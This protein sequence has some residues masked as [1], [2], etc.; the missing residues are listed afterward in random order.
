VLSRGGRCGG[1]FEY[2]VTNSAGLTS[3]VYGAR[4]LLQCRFVAC[5]RCCLEPVFTP[6]ALMNRTDTRHIRSGDGLA[7]HLIMNR[8]LVRRRIL[9]TV[10]ELFGFNDDFICE[11]AL[12]PASSKTICTICFGP[13]PIGGVSVVLALYRLP[14]TDSLARFGVLSMC[15]CQRLLCAYRCAACLI[16]CSVVR[17]CARMIVS[18]Q[19][20]MFSN[21]V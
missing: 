5:A 8:S 20:N 3:A 15:S 19:G 14:A 10:C 13:G 16:V 21:N 1:S 9:Q 12:R 18:D 17:L 2:A 11:F 4:L 7:L 6:Q